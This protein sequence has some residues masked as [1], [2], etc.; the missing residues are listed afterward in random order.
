[1]VPPGAGAPGGRPVPAQVLQ[2]GACGYESVLA[3]RGRIHDNTGRH[4]IWVEPQ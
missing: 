2:S 1:V 3:L 4:Y